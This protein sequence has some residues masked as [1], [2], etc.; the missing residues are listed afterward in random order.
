MTSYS[1]IPLYTG[2]TDFSNVPVPENRSINFDAHCSRRACKLN[3]CS[4][5]AVAVPGFREWSTK[6]GER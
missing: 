2:M 4:D 1:I 6:Y 3:Y 5:G